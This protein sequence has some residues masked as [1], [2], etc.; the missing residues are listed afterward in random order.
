MQIL[1]AQAAQAHKGAL[2]A[3][4]SADKRPTSHQRLPCLVTCQLNIARIAQLMRLRLRQQAAITLLWRKSP[5]K[6]NA[7]LPDLSPA[8]KT[9]R[10]VYIPARR[11]LCQGAPQGCA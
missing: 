1:C 11:S 6:K 7:L 2:Y 9:T 3:L 8:P 5:L 4:K 10:T